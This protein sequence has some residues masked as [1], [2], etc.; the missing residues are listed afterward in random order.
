MGRLWAGIR[1]SS[2]HQAQDV[3]SGV[4]TQPFRKL[5]LIQ[6]ALGGADDDG[7]ISVAVE[8][9]WMPFNAKTAFID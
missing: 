7:P 9:I 5:A 4:P 8:V 2:G 3:G 1:P 6:R